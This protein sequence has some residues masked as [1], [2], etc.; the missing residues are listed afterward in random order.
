M[1]PETFLQNVGNLPIPRKDCE[2]HG[3]QKRECC[4]LNWA[5]DMT[6]DPQRRK[7]EEEEETKEH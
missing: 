3:H 4:G 2:H 5:L 1:F 6:E 7:K